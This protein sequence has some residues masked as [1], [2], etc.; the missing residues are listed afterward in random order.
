[1]IG[2]SLKMMKYFPHEHKSMIQI[3]HA[4][5]SLY[6]CVKPFCNMKQHINPPADS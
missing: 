6:V 4:N 3:L 2:Y 1:M 5:P